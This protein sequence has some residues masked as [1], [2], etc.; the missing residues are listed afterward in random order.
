MSLG[1]LCVLELLLRAVSRSLSSSLPFPF[2]P[3]CRDSI[4]L[5]PR[6]PA[7]RCSQGKSLG[8][9]I[10]QDQEGW[11]RRAGPMSF[12]RHQGMFGASTPQAV[13][14][15]L[16]LKAKLKCWTENEK[17]LILRKAKVEI[18]CSNVIVWA[19]W[20]LYA[21][22]MYVDAYYKVR[23]DMILHCEL[24]TLNKIKAFQLS[25]LVW[26]GHFGTY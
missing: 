26:L 21:R 2:L 25:L 4:T 14:Y 11:N 24:S 9:S 6:L 12:W 20:A 13:I 19:F 3:W 5:A 18:Y 16:S 23:V 15:T 22:V 7:I 17:G 1:A 8:W 10:D